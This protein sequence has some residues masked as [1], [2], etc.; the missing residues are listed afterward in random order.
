MT[1]DNIHMQKPAQLNWRCPGTV[2]KTMP[3]A[4]WDIPTCLASGWAWA[5][6]TGDG[7]QRKF[8]QDVKRNEKENERDLPTSVVEFTSLQSPN[9]RLEAACGLPGGHTQATSEDSR[10]RF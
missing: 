4:P 6:V 10:L 5:N 1:Q 7:H 2:A 9:R 8:G 3:E